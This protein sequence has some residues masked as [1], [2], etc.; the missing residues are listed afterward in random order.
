VAPQWGVLSR[1]WYSAWHASASVFRRCASP[2][3]ASGIARCAHSTA[4]QSLE[5]TESSVRFSPSAGIRW[6]PIRVLQPGGDVMTADPFALD[7]PLLQF[8][9]GDLWT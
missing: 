1:P 7:R 4:R 8:A 3:S 2:I 9:P 5:P 6:R